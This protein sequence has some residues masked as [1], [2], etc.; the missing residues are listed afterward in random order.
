MVLTSAELLI[1]SLDL[2]TAR[3]IE[4]KV[5]NDHYHFPPPHQKKTTPVINSYAT[6]NL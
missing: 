2:W 3:F 4:P 1:Q 5:V 6:Y